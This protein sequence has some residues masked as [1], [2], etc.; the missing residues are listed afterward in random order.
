MS[1]LPEDFLN[2]MKEMMGEEYEAFYEGYQGIR[3]SAFRINS[4]KAEKEEFLK[5]TQNMQ[6]FAPLGE[7]T[8][9][10]NGI[11]YDR[12]VSFPG[13]H[14]FHEAGVYYIQEPSAMAPVPFL[15]CMPG[16]K[17]LDLCA[18]PGGKSTQLASYLGGEGL[19]VANEIH[20]QRAKILSENVERMGI[21]NCLVT[22]ETPEKLAQLFPGF[23]DKI[24]VDAPCSGE[25]MFRK[26][27]NAGEEW[28][29]ENVEN[30]AQRQAGILDCAAEMLKKGGRLVYSTCTFAPSENE[31]GICDFLDRHPEFYEAKLE[32]NQVPEGI[33]HGKHYEG[34]RKGEEDAR[35]SACFRIWPHL[36]HG[37]GH[38]LAVLCK[39]GEEMGEI[40]PQN[41]FIK[42]KNIK[43][44]K[45]LQEFLEE[46]LTE[47]G[48]ER[49]CSGKV[50][51]FGDQLYLCPENMP[52]LQKL[53]V[54]RPGLHLGTM[55]KNRFEPSHALALA[56]RPGECRHTYEVNLETG[57]ARSY[58]E[59][60]T[61]QPA[62]TAEMEKG[63]YLITVC[64][65]SIGFAKM[66]GGILKN[67]YPKGLR[68]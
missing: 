53:K 58:L 52:S 35:L 23:F 15:Q 7:V 9:E 30:C 64:G 37:E 44:Y 28:S 6:D 36:A 11:Y 16:E 55:K 20:P 41:G 66:A 54:L 65:Y 10:K 22:N 59:G 57:E 32:E 29:L 40:S 56:L 39:D 18:A 19:L 4:L 1:Q 46:T 38:F 67:H 27:E 17:V 14:P 34:M 61:L 25:G 3:Y 47:E 68:K 42:G 43:D 49:I 33:V 51:A 2:R 21:T 24:L 12:E 45:E 50:I 63:W 60:M 31:E 5:L 62:D 26:N 13:K 48:K 8:W